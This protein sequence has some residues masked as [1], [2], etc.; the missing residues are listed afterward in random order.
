ME[1]GVYSSKC[2]SEQ[3]CGLCINAC[4]QQAL[5]FGEEKIFGIDRSR[6]VGCTKCVDAC[7]TEAIRRWGEYMP[8][9]DV[10]AVIEKDRAYYESSGG[11]VTV[12]GGEPLVQHEFTASLLK[13]CRDAGIHTCLESTFFTEWDVIEE[14]IKYVDLII[15]D[16]KHIDSDIHRKHT[17][18]GCEKILKNLARLADEGREMILRIPVIPGV[19]DDMENISRTADFIEENIGDSLRTL[20]L[21]SF[22]RMGEEKRRS[23]GRTYEMDELEFDREDFQKKVETIAEYFNGR[24]IHCVVGTKEKQ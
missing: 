3:K 2:I 21:L 16:I 5:L 19:N 23:L 4:R 6:C 11:G 9:D 1:P 8:L 7:P 14:T 17:G 13:A 22:M 12:S 15:S 20:Q 10:M 18:V 24:G